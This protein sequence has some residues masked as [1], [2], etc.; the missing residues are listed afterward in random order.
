M[1]NA[2]RAKKKDDKDKK[3]VEI[4]L[5][6]KNAKKLDLNSDVE[7]FFKVNP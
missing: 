1:N 3:K 7:Y 6:S 5:F 4:K 2:W